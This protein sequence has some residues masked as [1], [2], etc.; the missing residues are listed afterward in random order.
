MSN[1]NERCLDRCFDEKAEKWAGKHPN[2]KIEYLLERIIL[3][4]TKE[5]DYILRSICWWW[6]LR[7]CYEAISRR[8]IGIDA[9]K[10]YLK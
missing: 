8:F 3:A 5:G 10:K 4:S 7:C 1:T 9:E 2:T 6:Q